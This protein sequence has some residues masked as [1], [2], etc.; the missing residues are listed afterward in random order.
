[1]VHAGLL[2]YFKTPTTLGFWLGGDWELFAGD[3]SPLL[4]TC[5][6][7]ECEHVALVFS[8]EQSLRAHPCQCVCVNEPQ[9]LKSPLLRPCGTQSNTT[10]IW[11]ITSK[12]K[13]AFKGLSTSS[14][15]S[16]SL[17]YCWYT[18]ERFITFSIH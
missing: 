14:F 13:V 1:M 6:V 12:P 3:S 18:C 2:W 16:T 15:S 10:I 17:C 9:V 5:S 8:E 7:D 11:G 4:W